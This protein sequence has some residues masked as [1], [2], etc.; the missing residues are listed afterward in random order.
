MQKTKKVAVYNISSSN[1]LSLKRGTNI[2]N[3]TLT[4]TNKEN[5]A[6]YY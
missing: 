2:T 1:L 5:R 6:D 4:K 3:M